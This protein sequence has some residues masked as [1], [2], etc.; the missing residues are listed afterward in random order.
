MT[1]YADIVDELKCLASKHLKKEDERKA[2][3][4]EFE[5]SLKTKEGKRSTAITG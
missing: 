4:N 3:E 2:F 1:D 5:S